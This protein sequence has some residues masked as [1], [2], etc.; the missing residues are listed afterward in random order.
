MEPYCTCVEV[1]EKICDQFLAQR[2]AAVIYLT[3][4]ENY[5]RETV[6]SQYFLELAK[7]S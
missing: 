1:L 3:N 7:Y 5:G 4:T 2:T 6:A